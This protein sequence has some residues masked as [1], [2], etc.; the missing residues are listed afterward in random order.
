M[1]KIVKVV[2]IGVVISLYAKELPKPEFTISKAKIIETKLPAPIIDTNRIWVG[3]T[4]NPT[5]EVVIG[6]Y[7]KGISDDT[8]RIITVQ[9]SGTNNLVIATDTSSSS[10]GKNKFRINLPYTFPSGAYAVAIGNIDGDEY[11]DI[12]VGLSSSP[13]TVYWFEWNDVLPGWELK[14]SF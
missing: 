10:F 6:K 4:V 7:F 14:G 13:Y 8:I 11:T 12:I 3:A 2:V 5:R 9:S 1:K